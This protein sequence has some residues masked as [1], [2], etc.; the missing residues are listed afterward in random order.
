MDWNGHCNVEYSAGVRCVLYLYK[1]L[2]KGPKNSSFFLNSKNDD[3]E[4]RDEISLYIKG[5]F[6][7]SMDAMWR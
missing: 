6:L 2:Y 1:Y 7:C 3:N 4:G 5:R